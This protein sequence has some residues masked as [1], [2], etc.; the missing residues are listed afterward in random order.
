MG[1]KT[2][3]VYRPITNPNLESLTL[4]SSER[5]STIVQGK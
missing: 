2:N 3:K 4:A 5:V 1:T